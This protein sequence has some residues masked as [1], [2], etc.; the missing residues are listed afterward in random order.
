M[1][2]STAPD[3][4]GGAA[5]GCPPPD[6]GKEAGAA[7][8]NEE[9][10]IGVLPIERA[11]VDGAAPFTGGKAGSLTVPTFL[12]APF[13]GG[14][15]GSLTP[16]AWP[17]RGAGNAPCAQTGPEN[18]TTATTA[19]SGAINWRIINAVPSG[20]QTLSRQESDSVVGILRLLPV[21]NNPLNWAR[22]RRN[23]TPNRQ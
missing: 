22:A 17:G 12:A 23:A 5:K 18:V 9:E 10:G 8:P 20:P 11:A 7:L 19:M 4:V 2:L 15:A 1:Q 21:V 16:P 13:T 3:C 6:P 14:N